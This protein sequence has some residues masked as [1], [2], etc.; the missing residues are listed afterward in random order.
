MF[1]G[2]ERQQERSLEEHYLRHR[3]LILTILM[4][5]PLASAISKVVLDRTQD[6]GLKES[7]SERGS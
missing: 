4:I 5:S 3:I 2:Q 1:P 7:G 6:Y